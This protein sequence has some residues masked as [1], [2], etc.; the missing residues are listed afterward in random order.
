MSLTL[1]SA[2]N[3]LSNPINLFWTHF[4]FST[5][6]GS[7]T[8]SLALNAQSAYIPRPLE[9][10]IGRGTPASSHA[11]S[12]APAIAS[13]EA[14]PQI[15]L[16]YVSRSTKSVPIAFRYCDVVRWRDASFL[17]PQ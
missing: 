9:I 15:G 2:P 12:T 16:E 7:W 13:T 10:R 11:A 8:F 5:L 3:W 1:L 17:E 14:S 6:A 4:H